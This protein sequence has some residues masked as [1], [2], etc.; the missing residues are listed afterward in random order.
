M[1]DAH[2][3]V[4]K[5]L[6][7]EL[8]NGKRIEEILVLKALLAE[9]QLSVADL[10][11]EVWSKY[12]YYVTEATVLGVANVLS[13]GFFKPATRQKYGKHSLVELKENVFTLSDAFSA[14]VSNEEFRKYVE[15]LLDYSEARF[16]DLFEG[17][18]FVHGFVRYGKY[19]RKDVSRLLNYSLNMES[20][21]YGYQIIDHTCPIFVTYNKRDDITANTK[22]EDQF[23]T[24]QRFSWMTRAKVSL[25]SAQ[26]PK[27]MS[28]DTRRLLFVKK[29]DAE[30]G[31]FYYLGDV[32]IAEEPTEGTIRNDKGEL[33]P[34]VNFQ[35]NL[36]EPVDT[37]LYEYLNS[38]TQTGACH[39]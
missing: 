17:Q 15:D 11:L 32:Q 3:A 18:Q 23:L 39:Q 1:T 27:I 28:H 37:K 13:L 38:T 14:L 2:A 9:G 30:G 26:I 21:L 10:S 35:F 8:A 20:T 4:L 6:S 33:L 31:D 22:Y 24:P 7:L 25:K 34:I 29:S 36:D 16:R 12:H 5:M 19:T